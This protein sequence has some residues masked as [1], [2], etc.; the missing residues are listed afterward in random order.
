[1][2][3]YT[4]PK[5]AAFI[6]VVDF[7]GSFSTDPKDRKTV[8]WEIHKACRDTGFFY[9]THHGVRPELMNR[10]LDLAREFF[11]LPIEEKLEVDMRRSRYLRGYD[12]MTAQ[13]LDEGS[14]PDLKEGFMASNDLDENH[15]IPQPEV[16]QT[17]VNQWPRN[18]P[19]LR[20][21][22]EVYI[23]E[24]LRFGRHL[25]GCIALSLELPENY[26]AMGLVSPVSITRLAHYPPQ[27]KNAL[28]N[29]LGAGAHTD[30]GMV[31]MLLQDDV[32]GL[33]VQNADG[34][35]IAAPPLEDS[36]I[37]NLGDMMSIVTNGLYHSSMHRVLNNSSRRSRYSVPTFFDPNYRTLVECAPTCR[38]AEGEVEGTGVTVGEHINRMYR[39]TFGLAA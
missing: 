21:G 17:G 7:A 28:F 37:I 13:T 18:P 23:G 29:Q 31:T 4:P 16:K 20:A 27:P 9:A 24:M 15:P 3:V 38:S 5:A 39:K 8:A 25:M 6:P 19:H 22:Y 12:A 33:E 2:I 32:G 1:M 14:P 35:W 30:W 36:F 11:A 10:Q 34:D 26:F